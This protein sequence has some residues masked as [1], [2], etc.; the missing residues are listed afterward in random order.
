M[1]PPD[2]IDSDRGM[3]LAT[4]VPANPD[5]E[6]RS[7]ATTDNQGSTVNGASYVSSSSADFGQQIASGVR[8]GAAGY[9]S[10]SD[11]MTGGNGTH[12]GEARY[13]ANN[14]IARLKAEYGIDVDPVRVERA[15]HNE[16]RHHK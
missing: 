13:L 5:V 16:I 15:I 3:C 10:P 8:R 9:F 1:A 6:L 14:V 4:G 2:R 11:Y 7:I 12:N